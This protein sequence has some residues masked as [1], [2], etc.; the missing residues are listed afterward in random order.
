[1]INELIVFSAAAGI[2]FFG[3]AGEIFFKK[4]GISYY[5]FLIAIGIVLGPVFNV[6]P[7]EPLIPV[8]GLFASFTLIMILFYSGMDIKIKEVIKGSPRTVV[9]VTIYVVSS[10]FLIGISLHFILKWDLALA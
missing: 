9:Q 8:L 3:F 4:T 5:L 2:I 10:I 7:R 1:M 6:F